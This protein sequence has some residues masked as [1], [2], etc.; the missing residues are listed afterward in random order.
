MAQVPVCE[1]CY[2]ALKGGSRLCWLLGAVGGAVAAYF[3]MAY[4]VPAGIKLQ[5]CIL[6]SIAAAGVTTILLGWVIKAIV[7]DGFG[8]AKLNGLEQTIKFA[9]REYQ[10]LFNDRNPVPFRAPDRSRLGV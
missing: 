7:V 1:T 4:M 5:G 2:K 3:T 6:V 8:F 10:K 9:N